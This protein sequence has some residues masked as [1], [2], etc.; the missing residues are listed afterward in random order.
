MRH[1]WRNC[2]IAAGMTLLAACSDM[3]WDEGDQTVAST[4][5]TIDRTG[6]TSTTVPD[7]TEI[8]HQPASG[9]YVGALVDITDHTCEKTVDGWRVTGTATN[10]TVSPADYRIYVSLINGTAA[11]RALVETEVAGVAAGGRGSFDTMIALPDDDLRC[12]LR[13]ERRASGG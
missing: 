6:P 13:V 7:I 3:Q 9:D 2:V 12:V 11:T 5:A 4:G 8:V 10:P 1:V